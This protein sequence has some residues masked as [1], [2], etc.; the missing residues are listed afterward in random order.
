MTS[1]P[2]SPST[3]KPPLGFESLLPSKPTR[4]TIPPKPSAPGWSALPVPSL[5][6]APVM[7]LPVSWVSFSVIVS[8]SSNASGVSSSTLIE[9]VLP[10][11]SPS[12][13]V[14]V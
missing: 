8:V 12:P 6:P 9:S 13:S 14:T 2:N 3:V 4:L 11:V 1:E 7:T 10:T 5:V